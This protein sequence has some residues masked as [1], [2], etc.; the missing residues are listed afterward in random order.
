M[1]WPS[2][3]PTAGCWTPT[4]WR[5]DFFTLVYGTG[6]RWQEAAALDVASID[7]KRRVVVV[8]QVLRTATPPRSAPPPTAPPPGW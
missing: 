3:T 7:W 1:R 4:G 5:G 8:R 2:R 6:L